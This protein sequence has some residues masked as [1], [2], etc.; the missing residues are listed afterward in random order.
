MRPLTHHLTTLWKWLVAAGRGRAQSD[1]KSIPAESTEHEAI[2]HGPWLVGPV[3]G[4]VEP[5]AANLWVRGHEP[6]PVY[7]WVG[8]RHDLRDARLAGQAQRREDG[9]HA[10]VVRIEG[11]EPATRY[12]YTLTSSPTRPA[13]VET[14]PS[15]RTAPA[16]P[17]AVGPFTFVFGS[18]FAP[19]NP[20]GEGSVHRLLQLLER[21]DAPDFGLL[22]GDQVYPDQA[23]N[24]GL[25]RVA[26]TLE[27][28]REVYRIAWAQ[29]AWREALARLPWYMMWDDHEVD[30][31]WAWTTQDRIEA[32]IP[33][34]NR[35]W[36]WLR[37]A[38]PEARQLTRRRITAA[39]HA[40]WEHQLLHAPR[41]IR[42]PETA[43]D[44]RPL[45]L[46]SDRGHFSYAFT[47]GPAA[48]YVM[49][50]YSH[51][52][53]GPYGR[54]LMNSAQWADLEQWLLRVRDAYPIKFIVTPDT[55]F[56]HSLIPWGLAAWTDFPDDRRR[57]IHLLAAHQVDGVFLL[58]GDI[59]LGYA[60]EAYLEGA[61]GPLPVWEFTASPWGQATPPWGFKLS[62]IARVPGVRHAGWLA[63]WI[64][65]NFGWVRFAGGPRPWVQFRLETPDGPVYEARFVRMRQGWRRVQPEDEQGSTHA[66]SFRR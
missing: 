10:A 14:P 38:P 12:F 51:R 24:N 64:G 2:A 49:D 22:I 50:L 39:I 65:P 16:S 27:D 28:Y 1:A 25:G 9:G 33:W 43:P 66:S 19:H 52:V 32:Q 61:E 6:G 42:P 47:Y 17:R 37:H 45:L 58:S 18:C 11:L 29:T 5:H 21:D 57:L 7:A 56:H 40:F 46:T 59:H 35:F 44:G 53:S 48:F 41:L 63:R 4:A 3:V 34:L 30:N 8:Q 20:F 26:L 31:D 54:A 62:R 60:L 55:V 15:F 13:L 23:W 36:R